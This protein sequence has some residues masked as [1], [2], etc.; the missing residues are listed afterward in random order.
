MFLRRPA[1]LEG[2]TFQTLREEESDQLKSSCRSTWRE[3]LLERE[4]TR[5][6]LQV[7]CGR[8]YF[9]GDAY[10]GTIRNEGNLPGGG[11]GEKHGSGI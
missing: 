2:R 5:A 8:S 6:G 11:N 7:V 3:N 4:L 9:K 10:A 1:N